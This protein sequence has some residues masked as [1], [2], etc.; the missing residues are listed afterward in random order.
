VKTTFLSVKLTLLSVK[1]S[2]FDTLK[3]SHV[4]YVK[5]TFLGSFLGLLLYIFLNHGLEKLRFKNPNK[6]DL[7]RPPTGIELAIV[8]SVAQPF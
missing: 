4:D 2:R 6:P 1:T 7:D 8:E 5:F 3:N